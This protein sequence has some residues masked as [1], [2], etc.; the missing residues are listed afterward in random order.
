MFQISLEM[1]DGLIQVEVGGGGG[2]EL[3][4]K[5]PEYIVP[6][7]TP[8]PFQIFYFSCIFQIN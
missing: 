8:N 4:S 7:P 3:V 6:Y 1:K 5:K 2:G